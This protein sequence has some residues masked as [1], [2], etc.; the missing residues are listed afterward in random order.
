MLHPSLITDSL[1]I[2]SHRPPPISSLPVPP[3]HPPSLS[4][5]SRRMRTW[6]PHTCVPGSG[7]SGC[8]TTHMQFIQSFSSPRTRARCVRGSTVAH[9]SYSY[10]AA[11]TAATAHGSW[12]PGSPVIRVE[13]RVRARLRV[14]E[15]RGRGLESGS[16][17][18]SGFADADHVRVALALSLSLTLYPTCAVSPRR[19]RPPAPSRT[20]PPLRKRARR[21]M[22]CPGGQ[23]P[24]SSRAG[25]L[26]LPSMQ[27]GN[28]VPLG[29]R[30]AART[31]RLLPRRWQRCHPG[32][33]P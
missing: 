15:V 19:P 21:A 1:P 16:G 4:L 30:G 9:C 5:P 14:S 17:S 28:Q 20:P 10:S 12:I 23:P 31:R 24:R 25:G 33:A 32:R 18:E 2:P 29:A 6:Q 11:A 3:S 27:A 26:P 8:P 13:L 7:S 22:R